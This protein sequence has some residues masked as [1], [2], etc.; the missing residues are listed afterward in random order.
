MWFHPKEPNIKLDSTIDASLLKDD[1]LGLYNAYRNEVEFTKNDLAE[2]DE[3][4]ALA[5]PILNQRKKLEPFLSDQETEGSNN[6]IVSGAK[7]ESGFPMLANDPHRKIA[8]PSLRYIVHLN[9]LLYT[10]PSPRD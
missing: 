9:C 4:D 1:I 6:W 3:D 5:L 8:V 7:S 10:S 2:Y